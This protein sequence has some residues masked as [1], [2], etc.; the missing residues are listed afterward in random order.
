MNPWMVFIPVAV[1][2][3]AV[4]VIDHR[5]L[6]PVGIALLLGGFVGVF[7]VMHAVL[8]ADERERA[9]CLS[10]GGIPASGECWINGERQ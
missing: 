8:V 2:T 6:R 9:E 7:I 4:L 5:Q 10:R 3:S 1:M